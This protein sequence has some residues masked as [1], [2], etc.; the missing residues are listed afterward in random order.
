MRYPNKE[1]CVSQEFENADL[2]SFPAKPT[3]GQVIDILEKAG[4]NEILPSAVYYGLSGLSNGDLD[5]FRT[6]W[7]NLPVNYRQ[8]LASELANASEVNFEFDYNAF[9]LLAFTDSD[10]SVRIAAI[11]LLWANESLEYLSQLIDVAENDDSIEVRASAIGELGRFILLGEYGEIPEHA[12]IQAQ[13]VAIGFLND[14]T[15]D[16]Q[17]RRR[18]LEAISNSSIEFVSEAIAEAYESDEHDMRVSAIY[19]MG[20]SYNQEWQEIVLKEIHSADAEIRYEATRAAGELEIEEAIPLL[21]KVAVI[22]ERE[23][24]EVAIWS[25][26]EIGGIQAVRLLTAMAEDAEDANDED[27]LDAIEDALGY[28]SIAG[29]N[30]DMDFDPSQWN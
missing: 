16:L 17:V 15:E 21:G 10:A 9:G 5:T 24:Q 20:R 4:A 7:Q 26:G 30:L 2:D 6:I 28:A 1:W 18:A 8:K 13:D 14:I 11:D 12:S 3:L 25:L 29:A 19:A 27:L 22:D 23:I